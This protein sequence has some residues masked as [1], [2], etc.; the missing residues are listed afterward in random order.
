MANAQMNNEYPGFGSEYSCRYGS[1]EPGWRG[2]WFT[3]GALAVVRIATIPLS[4][5]SLLFVYN[6]FIIA[7]TT[8]LDKI[9]FDRFN[10]GDLITV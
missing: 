8:G 3:K 7:D 6:S 10:I 2:C 4:L 9:L 1:E 5:M